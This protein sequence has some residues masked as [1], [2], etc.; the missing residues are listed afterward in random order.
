MLR[1]GEM[2]KKGWANRSEGVS[3][4]AGYLGILRSDGLDPDQGPEVG[5]SSH[6]IGYKAHLNG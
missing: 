6:L 3:L 2:A 4:I 5:Y 1:D